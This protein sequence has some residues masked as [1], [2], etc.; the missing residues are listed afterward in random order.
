[1]TSAHIRLIARRQQIVTT[2]PHLPWQNLTLIAIHAACVV[3]RTSSQPCRSNQRRTTPAP[4]PAPKSPKHATHTLLLELRGPHAVRPRN[5]LH[6]RPPTQLTNRS[7]C[8]LT[9]VA[10]RHHASSAADPDLPDPRLL[11]ARGYR[12]FLFPP[13]FEQVLADTARRHPTS[14]EICRTKRELPS[15]DMPAIRSRL[16]FC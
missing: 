5:H 13:G 7:I 16:S 4:R 11:A 6:M 3:R 15:R 12:N 14:Y 1:M 9:V 10:A 8:A 2:S